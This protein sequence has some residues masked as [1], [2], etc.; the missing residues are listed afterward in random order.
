MRNLFIFSLLCTAVAGFA[1]VTRTIYEVTRALRE[2]AEP[3]PDPM[4]VAYLHCWSGTE[5]IFSVCLP[6]EQLNTSAGSV[7][8]GDWWIGAR[9]QPRTTITGAACLYE[10]APECSDE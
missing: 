2:T 9:G 5:M 7:G 4:L 1:V 8:S 6:V 10:P 3:E